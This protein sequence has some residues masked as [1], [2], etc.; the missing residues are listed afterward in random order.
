MYFTYAVFA[1]KKILISGNV[2]AIA[3]LLRYV[4]T[5]YS[6]DLQKNSKKFLG[7]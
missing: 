1:K 5:R 6:Y 4:G 7:T 2:I 3:W